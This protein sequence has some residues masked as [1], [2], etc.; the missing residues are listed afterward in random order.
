M[1]SRILNVTAHWVPF[2]ND[3]DQLEKENT[4]KKNNLH[5]D[6]VHHHM[7]I[8]DDYLQRNLHIVDSVRNAEVDC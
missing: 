7:W 4:K 6:I 3:H 2:L 1:S 8:V 5:R